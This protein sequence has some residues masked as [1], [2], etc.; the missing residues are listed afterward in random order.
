VGLC[1]G[2]SYFGPTGCTLPDDLTWNSLYRMLANS[3]SC[4]DVSK[5]TTCVENSIQATRTSNA[6][7]TSNA[8]TNILCL[9]VK[10]V[11]ISG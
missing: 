11:S 1:V 8:E 7:P 6:A 2:N 5:P 3:I 9:F 10:L 4:R